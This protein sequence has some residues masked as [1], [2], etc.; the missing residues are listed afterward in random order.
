MGFGLPAAI[1]AQIGRP[2]ELVI[3]IAG[4][5]SIQMCSQELATAV[6]EKL[7]VKVAIL[8][9]GYLGMVRQWQELFFDRRYSHT[10]LLR[11]NSPDFVKLAEA[12]GAMGMRIT[13]EDEVSRAIE[14]AIAYDGPVLM[15]FI[16]EKEENVFP[17][18]AP[19]ASLDDMIGG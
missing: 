10:D 4:D 16:V 8:D 14:E 19:G 3:D 7:P 6:I 11:G 17:M 12:Y 2:G 13:T 9:N 18:V 5:G 1:G 15:D